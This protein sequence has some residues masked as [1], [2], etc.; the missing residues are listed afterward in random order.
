MESIRSSQNLRK[1]RLSLE[2]SHH[3][4]SIILDS[5]RQFFLIIFIYEYQQNQNANTLQYYTWGIY[6]NFTN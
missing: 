1:I 5:T 6:W 2:N 4:S 3:K